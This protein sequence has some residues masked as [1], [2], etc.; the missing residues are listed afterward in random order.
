MA[1]LP[2]ML[3]ALAGNTRHRIAVVEFDSRPRTLLDFSSDPDAVE[4]AVYSM[5]PGDGGSGHSGFRV[6]RSRYARRR[7]QAKAERYG[8]SFVFWSHIPKIRFN[9]LVEDTVAATPWWCKTKGAKW[10]APEGSGSDV[11]KRGHHP[12]VH[13]SWNDAQSFCRWSGQLLP[14]EAEWEH[15]AAAVSIA[16]AMYLQNRNPKEFKVWIS[17]R[18]K[19]QCCRNRRVISRRAGRPTAAFLLRCM[20]AI[21]ICTCLTP[22]PGS[23]GLSPRSQPAIQTGRTMAS[24][25]I[26]V[27]P[28]PTAARSSVLR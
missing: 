15:S 21:S 9:H 12:V 4:N 10:D 17:V 28:L 1:Y 16:E 8:W 20:R 18:T 3:N 27:P 14:T 5:Q 24:M 7:A 25:F 6:V 2:I 11:S 22:I 13:V 23:G 19:S 26:F